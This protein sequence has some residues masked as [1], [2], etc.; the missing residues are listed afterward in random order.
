MSKAKDFTGVTQTKTGIPTRNI[1]WNSVGKCY[2]GQV[3]DPQALPL[4]NHDE[5]RQGAWTKGGRC[6]NRTRP[7]LDL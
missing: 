2:I 7:E 1:V 6:V 3:A 5:W 4:P